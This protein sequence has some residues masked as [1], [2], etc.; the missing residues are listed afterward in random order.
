MGS[1]TSAVT[2]DWVA[3]MQVTAVL[4][5]QEQ[6]EGRLGG[7]FCGCGSGFLDSGLIQS[8]HPRVSHSWGAAA[9]NACSGGSE[10][11]SCSL[12]RVFH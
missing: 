5:T 11:F 12:G 9:G 4:R 8:V 10:S 7:C 6:C 1:I 2:L 3:S